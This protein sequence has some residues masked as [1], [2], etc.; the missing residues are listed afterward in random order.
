MFVVYL[1]KNIS[2]S[3]LPVSAVTK[4]LSSPLEGQDTPALEVQELLHNLRVRLGEE[5][6]IYP[7]LSYAGM[8][9]GCLQIT[10]LFT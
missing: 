6:R 4:P 1:A 8:M 5:I 7:S 10:L 9:L 2:G 3:V